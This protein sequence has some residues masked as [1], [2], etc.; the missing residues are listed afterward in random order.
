MLFL[1]H[2]SSTNKNNRP[3]KFKL[4]AYMFPKRAGGTSKN[5]N[6]ASQTY[7]SKTS[8]TYCLNSRETMTFQSLILPITLNNLGSSIQGCLLHSPHIHWSLNRAGIEFPRRREVVL[9]FSRIENS[10]MTDQVVSVLTVPMNWLAMASS[11]MIPQLF[12]GLVYL[13]TR[14]HTS[15]IA[16]MMSST[17]VLQ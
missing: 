17:L 7:G 3:P 6:L 1:F 5:I 10:Y 4:L 13:I 11:L 14:K 12:C 16:Y 9:Y 2:P 8:R 15:H